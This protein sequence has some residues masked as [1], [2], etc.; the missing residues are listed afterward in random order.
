MSTPYAELIFEGVN[1]LADLSTHVFR[2]TKW[3]CTDPGR[4]S[5]DQSSA[6]HDAAE[7]RAAADAAAVKVTSRVVAAATA[8]KR[9]WLGC[10]SRAMPIN[11]LLREANFDPELPKG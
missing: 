3:L 2:A 9:S 10:R 1:I 8:Q 7:L 5:A 6:G 4:R 11:R